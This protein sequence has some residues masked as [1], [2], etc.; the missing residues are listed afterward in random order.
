MKT[1][2]CATC[3]SENVRRDA[4]AEWDTDSQQWELASI[5]DHAFCF[6]CDAETHLVEQP[7]GNGQGED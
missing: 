7:Y 3:G 4:W 2:V 5:Y 1:F 6:A